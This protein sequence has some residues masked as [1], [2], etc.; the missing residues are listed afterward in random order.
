MLFEPSAILAVELN[1]FVVCGC[2]K[3]R[4]KDAVTNQEWIP[5]LRLQRQS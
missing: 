1:S 2:P 5:T 3:A 4:V